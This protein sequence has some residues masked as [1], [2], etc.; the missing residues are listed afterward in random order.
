MR[1]NCTIRTF[2]ILNLVKNKVELEMLLIGFGEVSRTEALKWSRSSYEA[3]STATVIHKLSARFVFFMVGFESYLECL[4]VGILCYWL[5][6]C[7][8]CMLV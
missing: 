1:K 5:C 8:L 4:V 7:S 6:F 2:L 3:Q